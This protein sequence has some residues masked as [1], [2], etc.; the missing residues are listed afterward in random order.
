MRYDSED[1]AR[2]VEKRK[3]EFLARWLFAMA[4]AIGAVIAGALV[5][6]RK[7]VVPAVIIIVIVIFAVFKTFKKY[8]PTMLY[9][10]EIKGVN[11]KEHEVMCVREGKPIY[12]RFP[13]T[14]HNYSN[15]RTGDHPRHKIRGS[16][17][18]QLEDG[19]IYE[20]ANLNVAQLEFYEDGD[21]LLKPAGARYPEV[22]QR[23]V[24]R[25]VCPICGRINHKGADAC[26]SCGLLVLK[27]TEAEQKQESTL[28][29][30][31]ETSS[32]Q[33]QGTPFENIKETSPEEEQEICAQQA[34]G[35]FAE[36]KFIKKT[37]EIYQLR[38]PFMSV[39]TSIFLIEAEGRWLLV[40]CATTGEDVDGYLVSALSDMGLSLWN[41]DALFLTHRHSDH[42]GGLERVLELAPCIKVVDF[43]SERS[44]C[45]KTVDWPLSRKIVTFPLAGHT[46]DSAGV[47]DL[48]SGTLISG[49]GIQGAGI[50]KYRCL[51]SDFDSYFE[52]LDR[53]SADE[54]IK[55]ILFSHAY[56]P[57]L[58]DT[59]L[60]RE[61]VLE[62]LDV[63]RALAQ[64]K[65]DGLPV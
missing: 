61:A 48:R 57:W 36:K 35:A 2:R 58:A 51:V 43:A 9:S 46:A 4:L 63:C 62:C 22:A 30:I 8:K 14:P 17:Y 10:P 55:N 47:L 45:I 40:D 50:G 6:E 52:A 37:D 54:R 3:K 32:E 11:I 34:Q 53:I 41:I 7:F 29:N 21:V 28:E 16:V 44:S 59:V 60:G 18:M 5:P 13:N 19:N 23:E 65:K 15:H 26:G 12:R 1:I 33:V 49:D 25:Q 20:V 31:R 39:Y 42:S 27:E 56:E 64:K 38:V 24:D